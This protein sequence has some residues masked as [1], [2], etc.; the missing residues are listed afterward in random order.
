MPRLESRSKIRR[1]APEGHENLTIRLKGPHRAGVVD[2]CARAIDISESGI[3]LE[4]QAPLEPGELVEIVG[5]LKTADG[6][7]PA[8]RTAYVRWCSSVDGK[9]YRA[10]L[11]FE[12]AASRGP[13]ARDSPNDEEDHYEVLQLSPNA[14]PETIQRVFRILAQR[15]HPDNQQTG[16]VDLFRKVKQSYDVL[17]DPEKRAAYDVQ[18][19]AHRKDRLQIFSDWESS[20]G[21]EAEKRKRQGILALLYAQRISSPQQPS[22]S[23]RELEEALA[24]PREHLEFSLWFLKERKY[25]ARSDNNRHSITWEGVE[26]AEREAAE[27]EQPAKRDLQRP[28][29]AAPAFS[30]PA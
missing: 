22:V 2:F 4:V 19:N 25:L 14:D 20:T 6:R 15:Y 21:M 16:N 12:P 18:H 30:P 13:G 3:G 17:S 26:E 11:S 9:R 27:R 28:R 5:D 8:S 1:P 29:L 24:C 10:G 7:E 23:M